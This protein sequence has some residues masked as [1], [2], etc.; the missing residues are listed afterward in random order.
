MAPLSLSRSLQSLTSC[1]PSTTGTTSTS[2]SARWRWSTPL[3]GRYARRPNIASSGFL[4]RFISMCVIQLQWRHTQIHPILLKKQDRPNQPLC[5]WLHP[6]L[7][8]QQLD[9]IESFEKLRWNGVSVKCR[10][11]SGHVVVVVVVVKVRFS[12]FSPSS[13]GVFSSR[14]CL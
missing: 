2:S 12:L 6:L 5:E 1:T 8:L 3:W 9:D 13:G 14:S 10:R 7:V 4:D 11:V